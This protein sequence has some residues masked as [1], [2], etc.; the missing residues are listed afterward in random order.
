MLRF[1]AYAR[2]KRSLRTW[3]PS[4]NSGRIIRLDTTRGMIYFAFYSEAHGGDH[5]DTFP[6]L[7]QLDRVL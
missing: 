6:T 1:L 3:M 4:K 2:Q 5:N 7:S